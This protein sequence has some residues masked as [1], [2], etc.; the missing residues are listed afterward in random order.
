MLLLVY[1]PRKS[2]HTKLST[3]PHFLSTSHSWYSYLKSFRFCHLSPSIYTGG[4]SIIH[5]KVIFFFSLAINEYQLKKKKKIM[6]ER[7]GMRVQKERKNTPTKT[8]IAKGCYILYSSR[9]TFLLSGC[10]RKTK[11]IVNEKKKKKN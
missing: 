4:N 9:T 8:I 10:I 5:Y 3:W 1:Q 11:N 2:G 7:G 6:H